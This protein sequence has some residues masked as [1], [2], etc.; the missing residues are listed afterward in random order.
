MTLAHL[1]PH[2]GLCALLGTTAALCLTQHH[3]YRH[4][5][6]HGHTAKEHGM[7][8][9]YTNRRQGEERVH[10]ELTAADLSSLASG[11]PTRTAEL[12]ALVAAADRRLNAR[13]RQS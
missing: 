10:L 13:A 5:P 3:P 2:I 12:N 11:D 8:I 7:E 1:A 9:V 6:A 4:R